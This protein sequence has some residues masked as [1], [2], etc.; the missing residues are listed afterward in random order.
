MYSDDFSKISQLVIDYDFNNKNIEDLCGCPIN[1]SEID[2]IFADLNAGMN[3]FDFVILNN[4]IK[5][6]GIKKV[7][8]LG[9]GSTSQ[10]LDMSGVERKSFALIQAGGTIPL[11]YEK[12]DIFKNSEA[13][14]ESAK[15]SD[16][17]LID[18]LHSYDMS[19][20]Y[21]EHILKKC[22]KP[23]Y[24]HDVFDKGKNCYSEQTFWEKHIAGKSYN[25]IICSNAYPAQRTDE[26]YPQVCAIWEP[27]FD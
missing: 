27:I 13:I 20:F 6:K 16:L 22:K 26:I 23:V 7:T 21:F 12:C 2:N 19:S 17:I 3:S 4:Y 5:E 18:S 24:M 14:F 15:D 1:F 11:E 25:L 10:F 8:E 9:C